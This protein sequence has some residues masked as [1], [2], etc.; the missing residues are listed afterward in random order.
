[1][2]FLTFIYIFNQS[3]SCAAQVRSTGCCVLHR[4]GCRLR[5]YN[6]PRP[7]VVVG[8]SLHSSTSCRVV[9]LEID[10]CTRVLGR[11]R[12]CKIAGSTGRLQR[13]WHSLRWTCILRLG[14]LR[15]LANTVEVA[16]LGST[17]LAYYS[18]LGSVVSVR[19][20]CGRNQVFFSSRQLG[21]VL[22]RPGLSSEF[23]NGLGEQGHLV[24]I[25]L[26]D[27]VPLPLR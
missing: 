26:P 15:H 7:V 1:M 20:D 22:F 18:C 5:F 25:V 4:N 19:V 8:L 14:G 3:F 2:N 24:L 16:L 6:C 9:Q 10:I 12:P 11:R 13:I 17:G 27:V 21:V 23:L